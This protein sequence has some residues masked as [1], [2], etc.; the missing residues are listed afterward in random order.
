MKNKTTVISILI[1]AALAFLNSW[2]WYVHICACIC[3]SVCIY[4]FQ[5]NIAVCFSAFHTF[6][7]SL[8]FPYPIYS[9]PWS[10]SSLYLTEYTKQSFEMFLYFLSN[11]IFRGLQH[12]Q[13]LFFF[14]VVLC[15]PCRSQPARWAFSLPVTSTETFGPMHLHFCGWGFLPVKSGRGPQTPFLSPHLSCL[16]LLNSTGNLFST[17]SFWY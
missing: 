3:I 7:W 6:T 13:P 11:V 10:F 8:I 9:F 2:T 1:Y 5:I 14:L 17:Q 16:F 15:F 12:F 4:S